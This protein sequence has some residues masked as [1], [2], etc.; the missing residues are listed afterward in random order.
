LYPRSLYP[1]F[2][3]G[4]PYTGWV[5]F[6]YPL[7]GDIEVHI[8]TVDIEVPTRTIDQDAQNIKSV[9]TS[10]QNVRTSE[11]FTNLRTVTLYDINKER[12]GTININERTG[13]IYPQDI[14]TGDIDQ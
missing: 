10:D 1:R 3:G 12:T 5:G 14:R 7:T 11:I 13:E 6:D 2:A 8:R 9:L 4:V